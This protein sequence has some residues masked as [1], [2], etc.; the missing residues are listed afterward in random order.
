[1]KDALDYQNKAK[2]ARLKLI[3]TGVGA[4]V[5][6]AGG[7]F[8]AVNVMDGGGDKGS[9]AK[10]DP[11][12]SP[13][14]AVPS[15]DSAKKWTPRTAPRLHVKQGKTVKDGISVGFTHGPGG[16]LSAAV[17]HQQELDILDDEYARKQLADIVSRDSKQTI[18][19]HISDIRKLREGVGLAP[20]GTTPGGL[21]ITTQVKAARV[22]SLDKSGDVVI[23]WMSYDRIA[24]I[25]DKGPDKSPLL[26]ET[27]HA[28]Y[29]WQD[30]D[31][32][33]TEEP[34]YTKLVRGPRAYDPDS[35]YAWQ[36]QWRE[37][38]VE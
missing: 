30:D 14:T 8:L 10:S 1:M 5:L 12:A 22:T 31:W 26:G 2:R 34:Q 7:G 19:N 23:V 36:D 27:T 38:T 29:K 15:A 28:I 13:S 37:V 35:T 11:S 9:S 24:T 16:A 25:K 21:M 17:R 4:A 32:K 18:D 33:L 6:I 20:S 3:G